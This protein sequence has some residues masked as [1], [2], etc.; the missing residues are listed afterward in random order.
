[1]KKREE[2]HAEKTRNL[3]SQRF[4]GRLSCRLNSPLLVKTVRNGEKFN[5]K[6]Q[7]PTVKRVIEDP[8][9]AA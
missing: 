2:K 3:S 9:W 4:S 8:L 6:E 1:V 5:E 7:G